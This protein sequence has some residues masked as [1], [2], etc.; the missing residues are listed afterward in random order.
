ME[1]K[2]SREVNTRD[3]K[4]ERGSSQPLPALRKNPPKV[5]IRLISVVVQCYN[6]LVNK[7]L[8]LFP[9]Y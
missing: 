4:Q 1:K 8:L 7:E 5:F 3:R 6:H 2:V 9:V